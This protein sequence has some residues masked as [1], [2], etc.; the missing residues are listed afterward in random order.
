[1]F[2]TPWLHILLTI[3]K[4][5]KQKMKKVRPEWRRI[6]SSAKFKTSTI[7]LVLKLWPV[8]SPQ[9]INFCKKVIEI[10]TSKDKIQDYY[11][12]LLFIQWKLCHYWNFIIFQWKNPNQYP[13]NQNWVCFH[14]LIILGAVHHG[15]HGD[16]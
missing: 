2:L 7:F 14:H 11:I 10:F 15:I 6:C 5:L 1:M 8:A 4:K 9:E 12:L 13:H 16:L 3:K